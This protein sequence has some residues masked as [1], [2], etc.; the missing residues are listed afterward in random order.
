VVSR[1]YAYAGALLGFGAPLGYLVLRRL[2]SGRRLRWP[3]G[4]LA[5]ELKRQRFTYAYLAGATTSV[6]ALFGWALGRRQDLL[7]RS[8]G[9]LQRLRDEFAAVVAHDLRNPIQVLRL[10]SELL[11]EQA[12]D[13]QVVAPK[14]TVERIRR[15]TDGLAQMVED[16]LDASRIEADRLSL[17]SE[18]LALADTVAEL[19]ER[20]RPA[21]GTHPVEVAF[22]AP[23]PTVFADPQRLS[24]IVINLLDNSAKYSDEGKPIRV[25]VRTAP[26]GALL[27]VEDEGWGIAAED[28]PRLFDRFYQAKRARARKSGL[29]LGLYIVK[30]LVHAHGGRLSV[31]SQ[32]GRGSRFEIWLPSCA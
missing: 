30:G 5:A 22:D 1:R 10:Q 29:G 25:Q 14:S 17:H 28:L 11:L 8:H 13:D 24:Q 9:E 15:A 7:A 6:V 18:R 21:L 20:H 2:T 27:A 31:K 19:V 12:D 32:L 23:S 26:G 16:L 3:R 4:G